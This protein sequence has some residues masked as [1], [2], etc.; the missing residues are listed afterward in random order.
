MKWLMTAVLTLCATPVLAQAPAPAPANPAVSSVRSIYTAARGYVLAAAE[1]MPAEDYGFRPTETVRTF[2]QLVGHVA[3]AEGAIC[4]AVL[5]EQRQ[6]V[7]NAEQLTDK[8][9][10]IAALRASNAICDRAYAISDEAALRTVRLF[11]QERTALA[12]LVMNAGHD[13]EH[14]GNIV[15]YMRIKGMV[16]PSSQ[17][18]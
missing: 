6:N 12:A 11:G 7:Q 13:F 8:A 18:N 14:Y 2:G 16:P 15:T 5:G 1:Q 3:N 17:G 4:S 10:I 9:A